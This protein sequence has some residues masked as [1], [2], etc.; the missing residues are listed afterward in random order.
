MRSTPTDPRRRAW[1]GG[2]ARPGL[3]RRAAG[4]VLV[5]GWVCGGPA[6]AQAEPPSPQPTPRVVDVRLNGEPLGEASVVLQVGDR[7]FIPASTL[8]RWRLRPP[9]PPIPLDGEPHHDLGAW[10]PRL[11]PASQSLQLTLDAADWGE[12]REAWTSPRDDIPALPARNT[13]GLA[14]DYSVQIDRD[15]GGTR[16][17]TLTDW[18]LVG[19]APGLV[20]RHTVLWRH[21]RAYPGEPRQQRLDTA[22][23]HADPARLRRSTVGDTLSCGGAL[24]PVVRLGGLQVHTDHGLQPDR[25]IHPLPA[26]RGSAVVPSAIDLLVN[27]QSMGEST[28]SPGVFEFDQLPVPTGAGDLRL[29]QRDAQGV[30]RVMT[31]PYYVSPRL[32]RPGLREHCLELG[33]LR[34]DYGLPA[35]RYRGRL[36]AW[37]GRW[38]VSDSL[39]ALARV[40]A[41]SAV[42][43]LHAGVHWVPGGLGVLSLQTSVGRSPDGRGLGARLGWERLAPDHHLAVSAEAS[44]PAL[45][46]VDGSR[47]PRQ[48]VSVFGGA[49]WGGTGATVGHVWQRTASGGPQRVWTAALHTRAGDRGQLGITALRRGGRWDLAL[50]FSRPLERD[51]S[52]AVRVQ[53]GAQPDLA[54]QAQRAEPEAGGSGW[55]LQ[56]GSRP[57]R[58]ALGWSWLNDHGR[59]ELQA[60]RLGPTGT[61]ARASWQGGWLWLGDQAVTG[62]SLGEAATARVELDGLPG[63]PVW[64]NRRPVAVTDAHGRAWLHGLRP[65]EDN[66]IGIDADRLPIDAVVP[67]HEW[68]LRPPGESVV[69]ARLPVRRARAALLQVRLADG[70]PV[71]AGSWLADR[72]GRRLPGARFAAG[73]WVFL[74][75]LHPTEGSALP[76]GAAPAGSLI[77]ETPDGACRIDGVTPPS[78]DPQPTVGPLTCHEVPP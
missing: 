37:G 1:P 55:R 34:V 3:A 5:M 71:P 24:A 42:R 8:V 51:T 4:V 19:T 31:V 49:R 20:L 56:A 41:G 28:V 53:A 2:A 13:P 29:I 7:W 62:R 23:R 39:T 70:R 76:G 32:L 36:A 21:Q 74:N 6:A 78:D 10:R 18:R 38:G 12:R 67:A 52:V 47:P 46:H 9:S 30:E 58:A 65:W 27:G 11:E 16:S 75:N 15:G 35:D 54:V 66:V 61:A 69:A 50:L 73:G 57:G 22:L 44:S 40:E 77:V 43:N 72:T 48:R 59:L 64:L 33:R 25:V 68:R 17:S 26:V 60:S 14:L 63:I 45:R